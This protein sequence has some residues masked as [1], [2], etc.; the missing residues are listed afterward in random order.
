MVK[1][2]SFKVSQGSTA[3]RVG[4][5]L[6]KGLAES[7]PKEVNQYR[8]SQGLQN[9]AKNAQNL[10]PLE[11]AA[12]AYSIPGITAQM[13]QALPDLL[14]LQQERQLAVNQGIPASTDQTDK[15]LKTNEKQTVN[16]DEPRNE[17]ENLFNLSDKLPLNQQGIT[18]QYPIQAALSD[19]REPSQQELFSKRAEILKQN[20]W[21]SVPAATAQAEDYFSRE[22]RQKTA[23]IE[24]GQRQ[25][26]LQSKVD[27]EFEK[28]FNLLTKKNKEAYSG[29]AY[30]DMRDAAREEV[31]SGELTPSQ[32]A[33]KYSKI[34]LAVEENLNRIDQMAK[35]PYITQKGSLVRGNIDRGAG[36]WKQAGRSKEYSNHLQ[37]KFKVSP[38]MGN[39]MAFRPDDDKAMNSIINKYKPA[40]PTGL[41]GLPNTEELSKKAT[42]IAKDIPAAA[43]GLCPCFIVFAKACAISG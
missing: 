16:K 39:Y 4:E 40:R 26:N 42:E 35:T 29:E 10:S 2:G 11:A 21:M 3:G 28:E 23:Q 33:R 36:L 5:S 41:T 24:K 22:N 12:Q 25:E 19:I 32:A 18:T 31:A 15:N 38:E 6:G 9:F 7:I 8:L 37:T 17:R 27:D 43:S 13:A 14:R 20:P 1:S 34:A 30:Q